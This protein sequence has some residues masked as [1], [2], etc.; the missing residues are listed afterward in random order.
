VGVFVNLVDHLPGRTDRDEAPT[1]GLELLDQRLWDL[2]RG[3]PNM[4]RIERSD[5]RGSCVTLG[6]RQVLSS[7]P[8]SSVAADDFDLAAVERAGGA[9]R[10]AQVCEREVNERVDVLDAEDRALVA[11]EFV[12]YGEQVATARA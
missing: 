10:F 12:H 4:Y 5:V 8:G 9:R 11:D 3:S 1:R 6:L 2:G 7:R